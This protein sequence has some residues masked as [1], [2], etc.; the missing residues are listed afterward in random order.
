MLVRRQRC[1]L[2]RRS[3]RVRHSFPPYVLSPSPAFSSPLFSLTRDNV[4]DEHGLSRSAQGSVPGWRTRIVTGRS[5]RREYLARASSPLRRSRRTR[6]ERIE[7]A[8]PRCDGVELVN[9]AEDW[10]TGWRLSDV[11]CPIGRFIM[12][13]SIH[14]LASSLLIDCKTCRPHL[15]PTSSMW[16]IRWM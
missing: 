16:Q 1:R 2:Q 9:G 10:D 11:D 7:S 6:H 8:V 4:Q 14:P 12:Y 3:D 15:E 13:V 5:T